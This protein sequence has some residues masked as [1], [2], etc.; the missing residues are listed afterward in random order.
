MF[1]L[2]IYELPQPLEWKKWRVHWVQQ[3]KTTYWNSNVNNSY[4]SWRVIRYLPSLN[5]FYRSFHKHENKTN[6]DFYALSLFVGTLFHSAWLPSLFN[7]S[8][9][10]ML[11]MLQYILEIRVG[12]HD[13]TTGTW[14]LLGFFKIKW[15]SWIFNRARIIVILE[16]KLS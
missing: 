12:Y 3:V 6:A 5:N 14:V 15:K 2:F 16:M 9:K 10:V 11:Q 7:F 4:E 1:V 13:S 8:L